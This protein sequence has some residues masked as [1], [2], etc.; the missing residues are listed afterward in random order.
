MTLTPNELVL[1]GL[2]TEDRACA[3]LIRRW[4]AGHNTKENTNE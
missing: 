1:L 3:W 2:M 4:L